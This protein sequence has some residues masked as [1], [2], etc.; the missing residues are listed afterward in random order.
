MIRVLVVDDSATARRHLGRVFGADAEYEIVGSAS[1]MAE[2]L[3]LAARVR[4]TLVSLDVFLAA[5]SAAEVVRRLLAAHPVPVVLV[6][7][8]PR[9]SPEVFEAL[10]A[11][12]LDLVHKPRAGDERGVDAFLKLMR[13]LSSVRVRP[14]P[15]SGAVFGPMRTHG[16]IAELIVVGSSTGGPAALRAFL[17][18]LSAAPHVPVVIAQHIAQGFE[19]G[20]A[21]WL[22]DA[23]GRRVR[24]V[25]AFEPV[26]A[27]GIYLG[28]S[29]QDLVLERPGG[30]ALGVVCRPANPRGYHPSADALFSS[31]AAHRPGRT[32]AVV[33][34]GIGADGAVGA[35]EV[36]ATGGTVFAQ[37]EA[38][39]VVFGMPGAV[40]RA[41]AATLVGSPAEL[42]EAAA[43][44]A[45]AE[46][47]GAPARAEGA[48]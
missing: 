42:G 39:A 25:S 46:R 32:L 2:A 17:Q 11:G 48:R 45:L 8:A 20:L 35:R 4:P 33:L 7:D 22:S 12:A 31:A 5:E 36:V 6:S 30:A 38:T 27:G 15:A 10:A 14:R 28:R 23:V 18:A 9:S 34:T 24:V 19:E 1:C 37:S 29:G 47:A 40:V 16:R 13:V 26:V 41:G 3:E 43:R 21:S 44:M